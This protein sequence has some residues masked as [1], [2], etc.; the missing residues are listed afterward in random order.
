MAVRWYSVVVDSGDHRALGRW[1]AEALGWRV[2]Y[3]G[4]DE[5]DVAPDED[6]EPHLCFVPV[7]DAKTGKNRL[8]LDLTPDDQA[9]EVE[10]LLGLGAR[11]ADVGQGEDVTWVVL[12]DPESNEFCVL[13][14]R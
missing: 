3:Q 8:H 12:Q 5:V 14:A 2:T 4:D 10:R 13:S 9:G 11:R 7:P 1:W 6:V